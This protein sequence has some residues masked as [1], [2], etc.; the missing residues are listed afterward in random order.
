M[1]L[2][3]RAF[4][5]RGNPLPPPR[6]QSPLLTV[7][8]GIGSV[9]IE[10]PI[11]RKP[12]LFVRVL[13]VAIGSEEIGAALSEAASAMTS[14]PCFSTSHRPAGPW[15][16][17][18]NS[19]PQSNP[20]TSANRG[21]QLL[22][23]GP[24]RLLLSWFRLVTGQARADVQ[25]MGP[26]IFPGAFYGL[27]RRHFLCRCL[28][29]FRAHYQYGVDRSIAARSLVASQIRCWFWRGSSWRGARFS[30]AG[31]GTHRAHQR[32]LT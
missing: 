16:A 9:A 10:G 30:S 12:N 13:M 17:L 29:W 8:D 20:S 28:P 3:V 14:R 19:P 27:F 15:P 6:P 4:N 25:R 2:A 24:G 11:L 26:G 21:I 31:L 1:A 5:D 7:Q 22:A 23:D 18:P 32:N